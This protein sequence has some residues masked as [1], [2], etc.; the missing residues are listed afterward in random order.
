MIAPGVRLDE[1]YEIVAPLGAGGMGE[2]YRAR[3]LRLHR[4]V[5]VKV[6]P[7]RLARDEGALGRFER[8]ARSL[9]ALSHPQIVALHDFGNHEGLTYAVMELLEGET[10]RQRLQRGTFAWVE[11]V[12][13]GAQMAEGLAAAHSKGVVHRDLKPENVI[14]SKTGALKI[15]DFGLARTDGPVPPSDQT[16]AS[17][18]TAPGVVL[19]TLSYMPPEQVRGQTV[20]PRGDIFALGC[21]LYEMVSGRPPFA[22]PTTADTVAALLTSA[23]ADLGSLALPPALEQAVLRALEKDPDLRFQSAQD[24]AFALRMIS[25][26]S[27][28][29][30]RPPR[31]REP[32]RCGRGTRGGASGSRP[33]SRCWRSRGGWPGRR[34]AGRPGSARWPCCPSRTRAATPSSTTSP[35]ASRTASSTTFRSCPTCA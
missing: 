26:V 13:L 14:L 3:D 27:R 5:A 11:A 34:G 35:T 7:Q 19:G 2:V 30:S 28:A 16:M 15:L 17:A 20:D 33:P 21:V 6:L 12:N 18:P 23:P 31:S 9:A 22:R 8:E 32:R 25:G 24:L 29:G 4:E 10:L 1:R